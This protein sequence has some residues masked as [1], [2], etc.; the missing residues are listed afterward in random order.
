MHTIVR[1]YL[2]RLFR[3]VGQEGVPRQGGLI[4]CSNHASTVDPPLLPAYVPRAD[5]WSMS[6]SENFRNPVLASL[7]RRYHAFPVVRH[8]ADRAAIR[9]SF[10]ILRGGEVLIMYPEGYRVPEGGM[11]V[12]EPGAGFLARASGALV[13]AVAL[14]GTRE[15]FPRGARWPRRVPVEV[16][17]GRRFR[18]RE[19]RLDG[20]RVENQEAADAIMLAIA[21][22]LP[23]EM[24]GAYADLEALRNRLD[25]VVE[26]EIA[27]A[28][29]RSP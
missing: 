8:S 29:K 7:Y 5:S 3:L 25:G 27:A 6:K 18:I 20:R 4:V 1:V 16:R 13:Q 19:R 11:Q 24:R 26:R 28:G 21:E 9:R 17:F 23:P 12:A 15:C 14:V 10:Q 2:G 22:E